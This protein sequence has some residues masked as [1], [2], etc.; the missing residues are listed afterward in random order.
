MQFKLILKL[1]QCFVGYAEFVYISLIHFDI[2]IINNFWV[3]FAGRD[4]GHPTC[5]RL[6]MVTL[7]VIQCIPVLR[8]SLFMNL[9]K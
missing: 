1:D 4:I 3:F 8:A 5:Y 6:F 2:N 7:N 9:H